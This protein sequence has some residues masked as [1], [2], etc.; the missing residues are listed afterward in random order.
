MFG[1]RNFVLFWSGQ[2]ISRLGNSIYTVGLAWSVYT[3]TGSAVAMGMILA[4]NALPQLALLLVGGRTA[5]RL[6][7]RVVIL[8][9]DS[10]G[11]A[12]LA[13]LT[14]A[15]VAHAITVPMLVLTAF[16]LGVVTAFHGPAYSAMNRDLVRAEQ[17][18]AANAV[19]TVSRNA[20]QAVGPPIAAFAYSFGGPAAIFGLDGASFVVAV[21]AMWCTKVP[22]A[23][24]ERSSSNLF[25]DISAGLR[26]VFSV[27]WL[28]LALVLSLIANFACVA[29]FLVLLPALVKAQHG[30]I[31]LLGALTTVEV[32]ASIASSILIGVFHFR[33][34]PGHLFLVLTLFMGAGTIIMGAF[35]GE[36]EALFLGAAL[37]GVG[38]SLDVIENTM[39]QA[40]VPGHLL[41]RVYSV[42]MIISFALL[43]LGFAAGGT[44]ARYLGV[45]WV[46]ASGGA[47]LICACAFAAVHPALRRS[48]DAR[49]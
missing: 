42:N 39:L 47:V 41:S 37:I 6:P 21:A 48:G 34:R 31:Y 3:I 9:A 2:T 33:L 45:T 4:V 36:I 30:S 10:T 11:T 16:I 1:Q 28:R 43:P 44:A 8:A 26:Y 14:F 18:R 22:N 12:V 40:L 25:Q 23:T 7:R 27:R 49:I 32:V 19:A 38:F 46:F 20:V 5:D 17:L 35:S 29:P 24:V 13:V 15:A